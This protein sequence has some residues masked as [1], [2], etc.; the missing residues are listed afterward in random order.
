MAP[1][2][3]FGPSAA[4]APEGATAVPG[5]AAASEAQAVTTAEGGARWGLTVAGNCGRRPGRPGP[6]RRG[7]LSYGTKTPCVTNR[8]WR[9]RVGVLTVVAAVVD[10]DLVERPD[11]ALPIEDVPGRRE[12]TVVP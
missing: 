10:V 11:R 2:K 6:V 7:R 1:V 3:G 8:N 12:F 4:A 5:P 9:R